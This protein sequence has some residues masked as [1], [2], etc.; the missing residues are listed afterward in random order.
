MFGLCDEV[1]QL[2]RDNQHFCIDGA[3]PSCHAVLLNGRDPG[4]AN[5]TS[6]LDFLQARSRKLGAEVSK[7]D[8]VE[9]IIHVVAII[10]PLPERRSGIIVNQIRKT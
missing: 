5:L 9:W 6:E 8:L 2:M 7:A 4:C 3:I 10:I 1:F